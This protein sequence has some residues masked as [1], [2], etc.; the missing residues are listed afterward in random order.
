MITFFLVGHSWHTG[1]VIPAAAIPEPLLPVRRFY[2]KYEYI[3]LSWGDED[4]FKSDEFKVGTLLK[5]ALLPSASVMHVVGFNGPVIDYFPL[6]DVIRLSLVEQNFL[7][8]CEF[9][10]NSFEYNQQGEMVNL[11]PGIYGISHFYQAHEKYYLPKTCN[12]WTAK[13]LQQAG[14][15]ISP[16]MTMR[17]ESLLKRMEEFGV[18]L[19]KK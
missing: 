4:F 15:P 18:R 5:A 6:S 10:S 19:D 3:E 7:Q 9:I 12:V 13:A 17:A 11:G 8:L 14:Y 16:Y 2:D 1:I